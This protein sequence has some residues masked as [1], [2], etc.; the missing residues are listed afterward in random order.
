MAAV[1][2][3]PVPPIDCQK[4][5]CVRL[6]RRTAGEAVGDLLGNLSG[7]FFFRPSFNHKSLPDMGKVEVIIKFIGH[8][9]GA[10][11]DTA[12]VRGSEI[13]EIRFTVALEIQLD[14]LQ[15]CGLVSFNGEMIMS[16]AV[17]DQ[18]SG[19]LA[20]G[21]QGISG[22]VFAFDIDWVKERYGGLDLVGAFEFVIAGFG[23]G[24]YFFWVRQFLV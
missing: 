7:L 4:T 16:L 14:V 21:Q 12:V 8:P 6:L 24:T 10:G 13:D 1:L 19:D 23:Q 9:N 11:L 15:Q 22:N 20:L 18:V 17:L 5:F 3:A 2:D